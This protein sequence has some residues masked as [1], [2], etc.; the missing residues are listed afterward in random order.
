MLSLKMSF[1]GSISQA[2]DSYK[3]LVKQADGLSMPDSPGAVHA[4]LCDS[5]RF[6]AEGDF[7]GVQFPQQFLLL[8]LLF[9][10]REAQDQL[11]E[12]TSKLIFII[13]M[14]N[15]IVQDKHKTE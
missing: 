12:G 14:I 10:I 8:V 5:E 15:N 4:L 6:E 13:H 9:L 3:M 1:H 11:V 7:P 2:Y